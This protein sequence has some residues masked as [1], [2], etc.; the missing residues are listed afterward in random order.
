MDL[1]VQLALIVPPAL[2]ASAVYFALVERPCMDPA[3]PSRLRAWLTARV[4]PHTRDDAAPEP[5]AL[6]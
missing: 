4:R 5:A 6:V 1:L 3:W 2:A